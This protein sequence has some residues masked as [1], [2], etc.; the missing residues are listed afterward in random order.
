MADKLSLT[1]PHFPRKLNEGNQRISEPVRLPSPFTVNLTPFCA[2]EFDKIPGAVALTI[3][4]YYRNSIERGM[5]GYP[6]YPEYD[7]FQVQV[8]IT[9]VAT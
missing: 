8:A 1:V 3:V 9:V 7:S 6:I 2:T 4:D 5:G